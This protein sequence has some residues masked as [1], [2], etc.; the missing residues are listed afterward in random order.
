MQDSNTISNV[1]DPHSWRQRVYLGQI[2]KTKKRA[3]D[4]LSYVQN[5]EEL[6]T[7]GAIV[8]VNRFFGSGKRWYP[9]TW[10]ETYVKVGFNPFGKVQLADWTKFS[11]SNLT[12]GQRL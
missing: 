8:N 12:M 3:L 7:L 2:Q 4:L 5:A 1:I 9:A 6:Q 11:Y 10:S